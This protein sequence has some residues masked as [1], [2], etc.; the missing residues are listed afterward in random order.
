MIGYFCAKYI[1]FDLKKWRGVTFNNT[2][3]SYKI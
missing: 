3:E 1:M 2:E